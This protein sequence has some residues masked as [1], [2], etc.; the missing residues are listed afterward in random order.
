MRGLGGLASAVTG[1]WLRMNYTHRYAFPSDLKLCRKGFVFQQDNG[2]KHAVTQRR[3]PGKSKEHTDRHAFLF[4]V[5]WRQPQHTSW[6]IFEKEKS[7]SYWNITG[8]AAVSWERLPAWCEFLHLQKRVESRPGVCSGK[9]RKWTDV[10]ILLAF[11]IWWQM[12]NQ[13]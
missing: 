2:P 3:S 5:S 12:L 1:D 4:T 11:N 8:L 7:E 10:Y 13:K 6:G 9:G